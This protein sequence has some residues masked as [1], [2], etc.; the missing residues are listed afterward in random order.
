MRAGILVRKHLFER[1]GRKASNRQWRQCYVVL[2]RGDLGMYKP[3]QQQQQQQQQQSVYQYTDFSLQLGHVSLRHALAQV[4][5]PPG[6][7]RTRQHVF[8]L[9]LPSGGVYLFQ[10]ES[11]EDLKR[12]VESCNYWAA[13][14]SKEP[15]L[16]SLDNVDYGWDE[17][18]AAEI[19]A[20]SSSGDSR[21]STST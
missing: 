11:A 10:A 14:E 6:Y 5:P 13:R 8:A 18:M 20:A 4:L 16:G 15:L 9:Q 17:L 19:A 1:T 21:A 12:W 3:A 7:S 2:E